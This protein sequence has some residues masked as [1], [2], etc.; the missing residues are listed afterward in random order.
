MS[1][2]LLVDDESVTR[3]GLLRSVPWAALGVSEIREARDGVEALRLTRQ[4]RPDIVVTDVRMP[5]LNGIDLAIEIRKQLP[6]VKLIFISGYSDKEYLR[7]A[8]RLGAVDYVEKPI[9]L[10]EFT[11]AIRQA[12]GQTAADVP[13]ELAPSGQPV[14]RKIALALKLIEEQYMD[15]GLN[16]TALADQV[17]LTQPYL[18]VLFKKTMGRSVSEYLLALRIEKSKLLLVEEDI[19]VGEVAHRVGYND[20]NAYAKAFKR[21]MGLSPAKFRQRYQR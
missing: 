16:V 13:E 20:A 9:N 3:R 17:R 11:Q 19:R 6:A 12:A 15:S 1:K 4:F 21:I 14:N 18:S 5:R 2:L 7:S 10:E 8:I